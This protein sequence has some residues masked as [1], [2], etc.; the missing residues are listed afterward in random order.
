MGH[1]S[2]DKVRHVTSTHYKPSKYTQKSSLESLLSST[3]LENRT[4]LLPAE[5]SD[6]RQVCHELAILQLQEHNEKN[7]IPLYTGC[8]AGKRAP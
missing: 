5:M 1:H 4:S 2:T 6:K 3:G 8:P 7:T